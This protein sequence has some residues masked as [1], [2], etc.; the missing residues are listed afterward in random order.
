[1]AHIVLAWEL[2]DSYGH[3]TDMVLLAELLSAAQHDISLVVP[4]PSILHEFS[5][6]PIYGKAKVYTAPKAG[7][8][9]RKLSRGPDNFS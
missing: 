6:S 7:R 1:M 4:N 2:G 9:A 3:I 8:V 5:S